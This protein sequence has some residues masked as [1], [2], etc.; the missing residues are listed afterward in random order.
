MGPS[1]W[2]ALRCGTPVPLKILLLRMA[3]AENRPLSHFKGARGRARTGKIP[4]S[5]AEPAGDPG[6]AC[7]AD[8]HGEKSQDYIEAVLTDEGRAWPTPLG[9]CGRSTPI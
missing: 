9:N 6:A 3:A 8:R 7:P 4:S 2:G 1:L 5:P